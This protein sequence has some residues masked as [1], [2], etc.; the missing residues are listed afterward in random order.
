MGE[1]WICRNEPQLT[2][3]F[4]HLRK[5]WDWS[6]PI[7]I[8]WS[9]GT[10]KSLGQN[11]LCHKWF[12]VIAEHLNKLPNRDGMYTK[13]DIKD[14]LKKRFGIRKRFIDPITSEEVQ[15]LKSMTDYKKGEMTEFMRQVEIFA[16]DINCLL[17]F[18]GEYESMRDAA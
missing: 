4:D 3:C 11:N 13:E 18:W 5:S 15:K 2:M 10:K 14:Y 8:E 12:S 7:S 17:P 1:G 9:D 6:K 16:S